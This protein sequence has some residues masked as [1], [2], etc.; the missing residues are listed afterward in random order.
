M[1]NTK[2]AQPSSQQAY[3][4]GTYSCK[5][6][7]QIKDIKD[8]LDMIGGQYHNASSFVGP[9]KDAWL[10]IA[11]TDRLTS[12]NHATNYVLPDM[13]IRVKIKFACLLTMPNNK[14]NIDNIGDEAGGG[15]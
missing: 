6:F 4:T 11:V 10:R 14:S 15:E 8:N 12:G 13:L 5:K 1:R 7:H 9:A 3:Q 2:E